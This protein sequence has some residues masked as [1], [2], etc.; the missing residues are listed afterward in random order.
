M[1]VADSKLPACTEVGARSQR[2]TLV[3][4]HG[5][6][7]RA[8]GWQDT[9]EHFAAQGWHALAWD[10][11][12]YGDSPAIEGLD[13]DHLADA[14]ESLLAHALVPRAVLVGHSLGGMVA[15][16]SWARHPQRIAGLVLAGSSP[17]FGHGSGDFQT[18]FLDDRLAPLEAGQTLADIAA[19][20]IPAMV[21]PGAAAEALSRAQACMASITPEG[22]RAALQALVEFEQRAALPTITVP[23]LCLAGEHDRTAAPAV[24]R[25]MAEKIPGASYVEMPGAGH[26][27]NFEQ[28]E[29]FAAELSTFL[30]THFP[31]ETQP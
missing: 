15:L 4:L 31:A 19:R 20:L 21:G 30:D 10:M 14:L 24:V 25:R 7:G 1:A 17:A 27:M 16:Q 23:T 28:P 5:I 26:L 9:L 18:R 2:P 13:F 29:A 11:P 8:W 12:G 3:F 22:Y 6:G